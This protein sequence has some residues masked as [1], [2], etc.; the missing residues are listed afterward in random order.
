MVSGRR[1]W[2]ILATLLQISRWNLEI[3]SA[4]NMIKYTGLLPAWP[5]LTL[6]TSL[7]PSTAIRISLLTN[8]LAYTHLDFHLQTW[9]LSWWINTMSCAPRAGITDSKISRTSPGRDLAVMISPQV[10]VWD[11]SIALSAVPSWEL[12]IMMS[13]TRWFGIF[14]NVTLWVSQATLFKKNVDVSRSRVVRLRVK[15]NR[16]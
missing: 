5:F 11:Q 13:V 12:D 1:W 15:I 4:P 14:E 8:A 2:P 3:N 6:H 16:P 9:P 10:R 7:R